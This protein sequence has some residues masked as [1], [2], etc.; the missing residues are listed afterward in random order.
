[1]ILHFLL[2]SRDTLTENDLR[3]AVE[4][5]FQTHI[6]KERITT[7]KGQTYD[8][9]GRNGV[10]E[11]LGADKKYYSLVARS[12]KGRFVEYRYN[13]DKYWWCGKGKDKH[14]STVI[15]DKMDPNFVI[16]M[17]PKHTQDNRF[18]SGPLHIRD[19]LLPVL[20]TAGAKNNSTWELIR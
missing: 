5:L 1:M 13:S 4:I 19:A 11:I 17:P 15:A 9:T 16:Q 18:R 20:I 14:L 3:V 7:L 8:L 10:W 2:Q 6:T 12:S